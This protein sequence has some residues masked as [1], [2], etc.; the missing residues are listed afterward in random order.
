MGG[1]DSEF[2]CDLI[3]Y[4]LNI[5]IQHV[6]REDIPSVLNAYIIDSEPKD[7]DPI[8]KNNTIPYY[9]QNK[10]KQQQ[11]QQQD[12]GTQPSSESSASSGNDDDSKSSTSFSL[13]VTHLPPSPRIQICGHKKR[14]NRCGMIAPIL[15]EQFIRELIARG[16]A[17]SNGID[18]GEEG[19]GA[20]GAQGG[21]EADGKESS[22]TCSG[23]GCDLGTVEVELISHVGG[24]K[25]AGNVIIQ[26]NKKG[27]GSVWYGRVFPEHIA[28]IV[29][30]TVINKEIVK[31]LYR[32]ST[33]DW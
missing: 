8:D 5:Y 10:R 27:L 20:Q 23:S 26:T 29:E 28:V 6:K 25:Y 19:Q 21:Q 14:D 3:I 13:T 11:Q 7:I 15:K 12:K 24:H 2:E 4:P 18:E 22:S 32:G 31:P 33:F 16:I 30:K 9:Y 1:V 17:C